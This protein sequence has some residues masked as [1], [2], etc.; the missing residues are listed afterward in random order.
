MAD[1]FALGSCRISNEFVIS[2][3]WNLPTLGDTS[4]HVADVS[5]CVNSVH[6]FMPRPFRMCDES[7]QRVLVPHTARRTG[8]LPCPFLF[9]INSALLP[10]VLSPP[11]VHSLDGLHDKDRQVIQGT[12][13]TLG[14]VTYAL[15]ADTLVNVVEVRLNPTARNSVHC[16]DVQRQVELHA[17]CLSQ[18]STGRAPGRPLDAPRADLLADLIEI[19]FHLSFGVHSP[20]PSGGLA[21]QAVKASNADQLAAVRNGCAAAAVFA[22]RASPQ[23]DNLSVDRTAS[24]LS[25]LKQLRRGAGITH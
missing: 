22:V 8:N 11:L 16:L 21:T 2:L 18:W 13:T 4:N 20:P 12:R 17:A 7:A 6:G 3:A 23:V 5:E 14:V 15:A 19:L 10:R 24:L 1:P 9:R 25:L